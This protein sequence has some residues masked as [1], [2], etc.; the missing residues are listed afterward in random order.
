[1]SNTHTPEALSIRF[2]L[3]KV[4]ISPRPVRGP[5]TEIIPDDTG[6]WGR[7]KCAAGMITAAIH[8]RQRAER[9][10]RFGG[11][12]LREMQAVRFA[13]LQMRS[14]ALWARVFARQIS[15]ADPRLSQLKREVDA[16]VAS[17]DHPTPAA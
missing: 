15:D 10:A 12:V 7:A 6:L 2:P 14:H 11:P 13:R 9:D 1:M 3:R 5:R 17:W 16:L 8:R 4:A